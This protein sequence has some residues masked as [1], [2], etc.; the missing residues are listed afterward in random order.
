[1]RVVGERGPADEGQ[2]AVIGQGAV[3]VFEGG[4][5]VGKE[6]DAEAGDHCIEFFMG[7]IVGLGVGF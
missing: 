3:E 2:A 7:E 6:H 4:D 1:V 5:R